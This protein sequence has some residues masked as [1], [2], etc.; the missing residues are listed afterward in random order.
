MILFGY[1]SRSQQLEAALANQKE[2]AA[3]AAA[4]QEQQQ[5]QSTM[6]YEHRRNNS[7][8]YQQQQHCYPYYYPQPKQL[9][10]A[11]FL[12][13]ELLPDSHGHSNG[14][15]STNGQNNYTRQQHLGP[16][17]QHQQQQHPQQQQNQRYRPT[18]F[19]YQQYQQQHVHQQQHGQQHHQQ[20]QQHHL[21]NSH[22]RRK[23]NG[24]NNGQTNA[25]T[26]KKPHYA[27]SNGGAVED[28]T[29]G[30]QQSIEI[31]PSNN[32]NA[33]HRRVQNG[34]SNKN[35]YYSHHYHPSMIDGG[36]NGGR[37]G[38]GTTGLPRTSPSSEHQH[39][40]NLTYV[41]VDGTAT[42]S[43]SGGIGVSGVSGVSTPTTSKPSLLLVK[44][45][46]S[47]T[48]ATTPPP[49]APQVPPNMFVPPPPPQQQQPQRPTALQLTMMLHSPISISSPPAATVTLTPSNM[50]SCAQLDEAITTAAAA[51]HSQ[52]GE[53]PTA[54][55]PNYLQQPPPPLPHLITSNNH[56]HHQQQAQVF[57]GYAETTTPASL[58]PL[59]PAL[60]LPSTSPCYG[61]GLRS[62]SPASS[63]CS[64]DQHSRNRLP[65]LSP[66]QLSPHLAEMN[67]AGVQHPFGVQAP[68]Q[69]SVAYSQTLA[70]PHPPPQLP[71]HPHYCSPHSP[72][73][74]AAA[75]AAAAA[76]GASPTA[77]Y[78]L[79]LPPDRYLTH[80]RN[81]ELVT[82]PEQLMC[83]CKY[84]NLSSDIWQRFCNAQQTHKKFKLKMRLWRHL[85]LW[86][87][88]MFARYR[89]CLVG[90]TITGFG[91]DSSD[92]DMCLLPEHPHPTPIYSQHGHHSHSHPNSQCQP[93]HE[94]RAEAL[95]ILNLFHSVLKNA[96]EFYQN[97]WALTAAYAAPSM[98]PTEVFQDFNL[99]EARVPILRF[100][101]ALND[102]EVDLNYNNC[103]G[104][105]NTYLLQLYAQ[106]DWRTRPLVV[107]VKLWAQYHDIND[108][109]RMTISSYS[110]VLMVIHYL[111]HGCIPHVLPC[112]HTLYPD[113]FQL[114][115]QDCLDL[116]LIEPI[117]PYQTLNKQTLGEHLLGFFQYFSQFDF[118]NLAISI[119]TGGVLPVNACRLAKAHK[120]DIHQWK[121]LN[122]EEPFDLSNTARSVY[123][124]ATFERVKAIF[125][126]SAHRLEHT[127]DLS[128][129]FMPIHYQQQQQQ[130][131]YHQ[132]QHQMPTN[133]GIR[134]VGSGTG[135]TTGG[136]GGATTA[137]V[138]AA[139]PNLA[140]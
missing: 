29:V 15:G 34:G 49:A 113:K 44:P 139:V 54:N 45:T 140:A 19:A 55:V 18:H 10:I 65:P 12:Q 111:Q 69:L 27:A 37:G 115:Q 4:A 67:T 119:R 88:P 125:V 42:G 81:M 137:G 8:N 9:T 11:S 116:D 80:A 112:L 114:S 33:L 86:I 35:T 13:K 129:I 130:Q 56:H 87:H 77:W 131:Q 70:P 93:H 31:L 30:Q 83:H 21:G 36:L 6:G 92:I 78:E 76:L 102:I 41:N 89:I 1:F 132:H 84:D 25:I 107:I 61:T 90:S 57:F 39:F 66:A 82:E 108:A 79:I 104:I 117:E 68:R 73:T 58:P 95:I 26:N 109:K 40:Y 85:F 59:Q 72:V 96:G 75:A 110:L 91:T 101:D 22:F 47:V 105:K 99:I 28:G 74:A 46:I 24:T 60:P 135:T 3:A 122:I 62:V 126:A 124:Y 133:H 2:V 121:E 100:R 138:T 7:N 71:H 120:N 64:L 106:L 52:S 17:Y 32:L 134:N 118:R 94:Q 48:T 5:Q 14:N 123:D 136:M 63:T 127:L 103:V 128:S 50:I 20:Q 23:H 97:T 53:K 16:G 98:H 51:S 43:N 38:S